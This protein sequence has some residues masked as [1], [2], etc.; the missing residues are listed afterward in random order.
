M[1][2]SR[3]LLFLIAGAA[4]CGPTYVVQGTPAP[5]RA[6]EPPPVPP[7]EVNIVRPEEGRV[8]VQTSRPAYLAVFEIV[9]G[10][11]AALVYPAPFRPRDVTLTG[12]T[13]VNVYWTM[14]YDYSRRVASAD[15]RYIYAVASDT[16]L[17]LSDDDYDRS[18]LQ[19]VLGS[20]YWSE[21]PNVTARA[22][23]SSYLRA[24]PDEWWGEDMYS[25]PLTSTRV[26]VAIRFVRVFCPGSAFFE[27]REDLADRVWCPSRTRG[28]AVHGN[29]RPSA[30]EPDSVIG[31]S[32]RRVGRRMNPAARTPVFRI[33]VPTEVGQQQGQP[34]PTP[35]RLPPG[36]PRT[37][38]QN[39]QVPTENQPPATLPPQ[40]Q[41]PATQ[42]PQNQ[43]PVT[44]PPQTQPPQN[45]PEDPN[46]RNKDHEDNGRRAHGDPRNSDPRG[47]G[48]G[49][50]NG[51]RE[52]PATQPPT[53]PS[54]PVTPPQSNPQPQQQGQPQPSG[55]GSQGHG[56]AGNAGNNGN[57][58]QGNGNAAKPEHSAADKGMAALL[59]RAPQ[60][61]KKNDKK[62]DKK[63][64]KAA[65]DSTDKKKP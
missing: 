23:S 26:T 8:L 39:P 13:W 18:H 37:P 50:G 4:A 20:A 56:N 22:I 32:G 54:P 27:V 34:T 41:P 2:F 14:R 53:P 57:N 15:T 6:P 36:I 38:P 31:T 12:L 65:N 61:A 21:S 17:R 1:R 19:R 25:M 3:S 60:S 47:N 28:V 24:Q 48:N 5:R 59:K 64:D 46:G 44:P 33:P 49:Y 11:G 45:P 58:G 7:L 55:N 30:A 63:D 52:Q 16:P 35:R 62:D 29:G 9:P 40:N 43:P 51:G 10:R 42:P